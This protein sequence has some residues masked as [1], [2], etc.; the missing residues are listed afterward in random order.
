VSSATQLTRQA[1]S[2]AAWAAAAAAPSGRTLRARPAPHPTDCPCARPAP[3]PALLRSAPS[4]P[5]SL[6]TPLSPPPSHATHRRGRGRLRVQHHAQPEGPLPRRG[7]ARVWSL[8]LHGSS[9]PASTA[10]TPQQGHCISTC[11]LPVWPTRTFGGR[12]AGG[13]LQP[14]LP[15]R[16]VSPGP[17]S[18]AASIAPRVAKG[19]TAQPHRRRRTPTT[20]MRSSASRPRISQPSHPFPPS[21]I[22]PPPQPPPHPT[23]PPA[24]CWSRATRSWATTSAPSR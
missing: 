21:A 20:R 5:A 10:H 24:A 17:A 6:P 3:P 19:R 23:P 9:R 14:G 22:Y 8:H 1:S 13:R 7:A 11:S 15:L 18:R 4:P 12:R 2:P 16:R